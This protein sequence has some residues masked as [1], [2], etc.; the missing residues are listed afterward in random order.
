MV[1]KRFSILTLFEYL[2]AFSLVLNCRS[3]Y[4]QQY[5]SNKF[6]NLI[7]IIMPIITTIMVA[8]ST[9]KIDESPNKMLGVI[10][11][12]LIFVITFL[13]CKSSNL[14]SVLPLIVI[15]ILAIINNYFDKKENVKILFKYKNIL[16]IIGVISLIL[17]LLSSLLNVIHSNK[18][19][20]IV[21]GGTHPI[22]S[23]GDIYFQTQTTPLFNLHIYRNS[24]IFTEG[25]MASLNFC[26]ALAIEMLL[27]PKI[28]KFNV[29]ILILSIITTFSVTGYIFVG[30]IILYKLLKNKKLSGAKYI[31]IIIFLIIAIPFAIYLINQR[32]DTSITNSGLLRKNDYQIVLT[33]LKT[34]PLFGGG[35]GNSGYLYSILPL[36]RILSGQ[37][38]ISNSVINIFINGGLYLFLVYCYA[39]G[40]GILE[41]LRAKNYDKMAFSVLILY[42]FL[43]TD[44]AL[45]WILLFIL[46]WMTQNQNSKLKIQE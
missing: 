3:V 32:T 28:N 9:K 4:I 42:L 25:P 18:T 22:N 19:M 16:V 29:I 23:F 7:I 36:W 45:Q 31:V 20:I 38:G 43:T 15:V 1:K 2:F 37:T 12:F 13:L 21:W 46:V 5:P 40:R 39:F 17:W 8:L 6:L 24:A 35:L 11:Y 14:K 26:I 44:F 27:C 10:F 30:L 33:S 34:S 41:S